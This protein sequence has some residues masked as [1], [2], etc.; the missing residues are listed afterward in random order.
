MR[1]PLS[2]PV[3]VAPFVTPCLQTDILDIYLPLLADPS[4]QTS[5]N[6]AQ[7]L[8]A[9]VRTDAHRTAV[10]NWL[11][12][13][14]RLKEIKGK[15]GWEKP[16][17]ARVPSRQGG[18]V[19]RALVA[20]LGRKDAKVA[21]FGLLQLCTELTCLMQLQEAV[22]YAIACLAEE[23]ASVAISLAIPSLENEGMHIFAHLRH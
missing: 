21:A 15:R 22:L 11:P 5:M 23:N 2:E 16:D 17:V 14:E 8:A 9:G 20:L 10:T 18:W 3:C 4:T 13:S 1:S 7:L 6:I 19:V 12:P